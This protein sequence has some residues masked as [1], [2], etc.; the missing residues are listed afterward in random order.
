[1]AAQTV[2]IYSM[3]VDQLVTTVE[4]LREL[5]EAARDEVADLRE[6]WYSPDE[7][8]SL[9]ERE[10]EGLEADLRSD[11]RREFGPLADTAHRI[12]SDLAWRSTTGDPDAQATEREVGGFLSLVRDSAA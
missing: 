1:M 2:D 11:R 7:H 8:G 4:E 10:M 3:S 9:V 6:T 12:L 5:L